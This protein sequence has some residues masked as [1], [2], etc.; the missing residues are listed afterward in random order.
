MLHTEKE[1]IYK[2]TLSSDDKV[3]TKCLHIA[4]SNYKSCKMQSNKLID[5]KLSLLN[6]YIFFLYVSK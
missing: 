1:N 2:L 4:V 5:L 6:Y 3:K